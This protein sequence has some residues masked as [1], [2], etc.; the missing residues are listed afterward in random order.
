MR[1]WSFISLK[2]STVMINYNSI[3][4]SIKQI[5]MWC[6]QNYQYKGQKTSKFHEEKV[7]S[8]LSMLEEIF[9]WNIVTFCV[10]SCSKS[11][12]SVMFNL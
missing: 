5:W 12:S 8:N 11:L 6:V 3:Y 4:R 2:N 7:E 9:R 10:I 1:N